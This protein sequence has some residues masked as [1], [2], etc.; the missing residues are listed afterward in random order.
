MIA[1]PWNL[2]P[3]LVDNLEEMDWEPRWFNLGR[4]GF[5]NAVKELDENMA[6]D[7]KTYK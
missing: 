4:D 2:L 3:G 6:K 1:V 7:I 5:I